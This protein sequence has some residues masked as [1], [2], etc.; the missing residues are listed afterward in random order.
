VRHE[1]G[2]VDD[3]TLEDNVIISGREQSIGARVNDPKPSRSASC[4][5]AST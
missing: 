4:S 2:V 3:E 5:G 1:S